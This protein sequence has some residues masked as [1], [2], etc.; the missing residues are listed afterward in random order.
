MVSDRWPLAICPWLER[1]PTGSCGCPQAQPAL[2]SR[3][4]EAGA[5]A[6]RIRARNVARIVTIAGCNN[7]KVRI[8]IISTSS[9]QGRA[10]AEV[11]RAK[12]APIAPA[13]R[14]SASLRLTRL[15]P[16][17]LKQLGRCPH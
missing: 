2:A 10:M 14:G 11:F 3:A 12:G 7:R 8:M 1:L 4:D 5:N 6:I 17:P 16:L 13:G 15:T 9:Y